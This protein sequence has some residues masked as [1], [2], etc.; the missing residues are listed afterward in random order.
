MHEN[1][2]KGRSFRMSM[3]EIILVIGIFA[4]ISLILT[5][6][7]M[8]TQK[9]QAKALDISKSYI[10]TES[11]AEQ[12]KTGAL[13]ISNTTEY[14]YDKEW[15]LSKEITERKIIIQPVNTQTVS[16]DGYASYEI[17]AF[18]K[19]TILVPAFVIAVACDY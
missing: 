2:T 19:D 17:S 18:N 3:L 10:L 7:F 11:I 12:V 4:I 6:L 15:N 14:F 8:G 5:Q 1:T 13:E 16:S 9:I